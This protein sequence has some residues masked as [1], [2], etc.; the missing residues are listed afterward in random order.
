MLPFSCFSNN[1]YLFHIGITVEILY[2]YTYLIYKTHVSFMYIHNAVFPV[3]V[4]AK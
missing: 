2:L 1:R 4:F 3:F